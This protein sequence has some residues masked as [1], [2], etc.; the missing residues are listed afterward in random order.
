MSKDGMSKDGM[1]KDGMS[2]H[3]AFNA[4]NTER[5][6]NLQIHFYLFW[7]QNMF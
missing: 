2:K 3:V 1:S 5:G 6:C 7:K 4:H